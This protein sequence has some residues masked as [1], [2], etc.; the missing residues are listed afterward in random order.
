MVAVDY[1]H[2]MGVTNR[3]IKL[4][5]FLLDSSP[6]PLLK[7]ADFGFSKDAVQH[8]APSTLVGTPA[9][10]AP[11]VVLNRPGQHYDGQHADVWSSGVALYVMATGQYPFCRAADEGH[12]TKQRM[13]A[14]L[15]RIAAAR[16]EEPR[17]SPELRDLLGKILVREPEGR[18]DIKVSCIFAGRSR[19]LP[20]APSRC[21]TPPRSDPVQGIMQH[22]WVTKDMASGM[23]A[24]NDSFVGAGSKQAA[25]EAVLLDVRALVKEAATVRRS[26]GDEAAG[27]VPQQLDT[28]DT[29]LPPRENSSTTRLINELMTGQRR[30]P[31][32]RLSGRHRRSG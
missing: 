4:E 14:M 25:S 26:P 17:C 31:G 32:P 19:S 15:R 16:F 24:F 22:P 10:L 21:R 2:R 23:L 27:Q 12:V 9:Y 28:E 18:L 20:P 7:L 5:N 29:K 13:N 6:R 11:E 30:D 8:S 3:D 1:C